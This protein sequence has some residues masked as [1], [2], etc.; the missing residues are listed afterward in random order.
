V[1]A[2]FVGETANSSLAERVAK[3]T[4]TQL[5]FL[6][7]GS[8]SAAEGPASSYLDLMR[9]DVSEIVKVLK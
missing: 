5:V 4:S 3:D 8:L 7:T 1:K 6:Y 9:Y 2:V